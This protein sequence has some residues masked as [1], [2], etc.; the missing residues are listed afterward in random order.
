MPNVVLS[1]EQENHL[2]YNW[3]LLPC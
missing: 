2:L 3:L 1:Y